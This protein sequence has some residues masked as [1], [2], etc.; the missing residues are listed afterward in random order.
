MSCNGL[1][2]ACPC[3]QEALMKL[4]ETVEKQDRF[5]REAGYKT[6]AWGRARADFGISADSVASVIRMARRVV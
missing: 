5:I 2:H 1:H 3:K 4:L 6:A